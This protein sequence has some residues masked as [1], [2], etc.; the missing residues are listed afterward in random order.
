MNQPKVQG[1]LL[2]FD[3]GLRRIGV[4]V[5]QT[6][7]QTANPLTILPA[8]NGKADWEQIAD[9]I[10]E[11]RP[12]ALVVGIPA[13]A[14]GSDNELSPRARRFARQLQG[15]FGKPV[16]SVDEHLSSHA[17]ASTG[18]RRPGEAIDDLAAARILEDW[19]KQ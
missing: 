17:A 18:E 6:V 12:A 8:D 10:R 14:D 19:L 3:Y 15:R 11:W 13:H 16:Y 4:A 1:T 2:G 5:G 7:T 9:L